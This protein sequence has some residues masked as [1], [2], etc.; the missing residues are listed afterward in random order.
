MNWSE[1]H[2]RSAYAHADRVRI[3]ADGGGGN[4]YNLRTWKKDLQD[5]LCDAFGLTVVLSHYPP[6]CSKSQFAGGPTGRIWQTSLQARPRSADR[7][8]SPA[9]VSR[10]REYFKYPPETYRRFR[11]RRPQFRSPETIANSQ[12]PAIGGPLWH[13]RGQSLRAPDCL[14]GDAGFELPYSQSKK[15]L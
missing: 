5:K 2:G 1:L 11:S 7:T 10:K 9:P 6:A 12:K 14:A 15:A 13:C 3:L 8:R 4:G